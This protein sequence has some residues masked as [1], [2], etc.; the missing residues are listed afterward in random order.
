MTHSF[1]RSKFN[2][3]QRFLGER[4]RFAKLFGKSDRTR[5]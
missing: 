4:S 3:S 1:E 5:V 2:G